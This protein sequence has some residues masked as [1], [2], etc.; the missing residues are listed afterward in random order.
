MITFLMIVGAS[1]AAWAFTYK[2]LKTKNSEEIAVLWRHFY[3]DLAKTNHHKRNQ[4]DIENNFRRSED[5]LQSTS[6]DLKYDPREEEIYNGDY[7]YPEV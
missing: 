1:F 6:E 4:S 2:C 7:S 3:D 5:F